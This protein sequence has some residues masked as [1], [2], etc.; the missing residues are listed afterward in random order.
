MP[1]MS[2]LH[3][4]ISFAKEAELS[5]HRAGMV[6]ARNGRL[7]ERLR[8]GGRVWPETED[9]IREAIKAERIKRGISQEGAAA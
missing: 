1:A 4:I 6:L 9:G 8:S 7:I 2:I 5:E 3:E